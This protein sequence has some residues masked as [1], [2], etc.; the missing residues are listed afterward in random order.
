[1]AFGSRPLCL[2]CN[3]SAIRGCQNHAAQTLSHDRAFRQGNADQEV[4]AVGAVGVP[5]PASIG[6]LGIG[7]AVVHLMR[8]RKIA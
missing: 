4:S 3:S 5:E 7:L 6:L 8:R 1:M 2:A